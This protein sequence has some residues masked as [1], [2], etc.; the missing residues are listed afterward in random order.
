M[1]V[2]YSLCCLFELDDIYK[3]HGKTTVSSEDDEDVEE[4][5]EYDEEEEE[6]EEGETELYSEPSVY[7]NLLNKLDSGSN[8]HADGNE[9]R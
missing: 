2:A 6:E 7:D 8:L 4:G 9:K 3:K 5:D 1:H